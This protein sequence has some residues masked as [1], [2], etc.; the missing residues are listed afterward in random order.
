MRY[1]FVTCWLLAFLLAAPALVLGQNQGG[2]ALLTPYAFT[3]LAQADATASG[4]NAVS[5]RY[6]ALPNGPAARRIHLKQT[7][8]FVVNSLSRRRVITRS[9]ALPNEQDPR[10]L[11]IDLNAYAI[12][13]K[14]W[15]LLAEKG[16]GAVPLP[17]PFFYI[18][19]ETT[20]NVYYPAGTNADGKTY[21]AG[22]YPTKKVTIKPGPWVLH[23]D[24]S[25]TWNSLTLATGACK[26]PILRADWFVAYASVAPAYYSLL[27]LKSKQEEFEELLQVDY[28]RASASQVA[29]VADSKQVTLHNRILIRIPT[30]QGLTGGYFWRSYDTSTGID[31][32]DY[33]NNLATFDNPDAEATEL[34][35]TLPN[36]LQAYAVANK[37]RLLINKA[38]AAIAIHSDKLPTKLTDKQIF[39]GLRNC[40]FCHYGLRPIECRARAIA[41][42]D[43]GLS[44]LFT[45]Q[46]KELKVQA[47]VADAFSPDINFLVEHDN[48]IH[49][50]AVR[51]VNGLEPI[52]NSH[53]LELAMYDYLEAP[54]TLESAALEAGYTPEELRALIRASTGVDHTLMGISQ[55]LQVPASRLNWERRGHIQL[56]LLTIPLKR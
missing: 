45:G 1:W 56:M 15:D 48:G 9:A 54:I 12:D 22:N 14:A 29:A 3:R 17:E 11:R 10:V 33:L 6:L 20:E 7:V 23:P 13:P 35:G 42:G 41:Q 19:V 5:Y 28:K 32:A 26:A 30:V 36:T 27:G 37:K 16:S 49:R 47:K 4:A 46:L 38:D 8:D 53:Q 40:T 50:A 31:K 52:A 34:I 43:I 24:N 51:A 21:T 18:S 55:K 2:V 39:T 25:A 44:Q